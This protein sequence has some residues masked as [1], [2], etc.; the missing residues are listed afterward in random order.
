[1]DAAWHL[2]SDGS[3]CTDPGAKYFER[4]HD[5]AIEAKRLQRRIEWLGYDVTISQFAA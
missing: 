1:L 4:R 5:P 2:L 3:L